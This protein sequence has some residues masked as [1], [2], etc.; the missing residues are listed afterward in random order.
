MCKSRAAE[1]TSTEELAMHR[2][3]AEHMYKLHGNRTDIERIQ[4]EMV[5]AA[6]NAPS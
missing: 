3:L 4:R 5:R 6:S 1:S 2:V